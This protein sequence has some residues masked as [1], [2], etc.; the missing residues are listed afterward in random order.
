MLRT[1]FKG[2]ANNCSMIENFQ[3]E[4]SLSYLLPGEVCMIFLKSE[5]DEYLFTDQALIRIVGESVNSPKRT[6]SRINYFESKF[7]GSISNSHFSDMV[8]DLLLPFLD[9]CFLTAGLADNDVRIKFVMGRETLEVEMKKEE[10][11]KEKP[12][13][14]HLV[15]H[16]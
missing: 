11:E 7:E 4:P 15:H 10:V 3:S 12:L 5:K 2:S 8:P 16:T 14:H 1:D 13:Y 9:V 6:I